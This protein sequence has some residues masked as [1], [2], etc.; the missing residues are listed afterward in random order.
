MYDAQLS[1][2]IF[3]E[4]MNG[5][6]INDVKLNNSSEFVE[7]ELFR[8]V[9]DNLS[10]YR[11]QYQMSGFELVENS[12]FF[13]IRDQSSTKDDLKTDLTMRACILLMI[14]GKYVTSQN[15]SM[16][17]LTSPKSGITA[18]DIEAME[19]SPD[20]TE[21]LEKANFK[22][23]LHTHIKR[24]L[25]DRNIMLETVGTKRYVL[26]KAGQ[27]FFEELADHYESH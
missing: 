8:E 27:A 4:L 21:L 10:D 2:E 25:V 11:T 15:Y 22:N 9:I 12:S 24:I 6:I 20:N 18:A 7:N 23:D 17:K 5:R 1:K 3:S 19:A 13:Y 16:S 14:I 26:G